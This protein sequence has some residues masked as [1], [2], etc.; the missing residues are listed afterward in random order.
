MRMLAKSPP[1]WW[2]IIT[3]DS[4]SQ[5]RSSGAKRRTEA[6]SGN[7]WKPY[8][9]KKRLRVVLYSAIGARLCHTR[10]K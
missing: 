8:S 3:S 6:Y 7:D 5:S 9:L 10:Q 1:R 2:A 4:M